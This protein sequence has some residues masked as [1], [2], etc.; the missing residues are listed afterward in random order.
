MIHQL[1]DLPF[2]SNHSFSKCEEQF[3]ADMKSSYGISV[4]Q[5]CLLKGASTQWHL[6][7]WADLRGAHEKTSEG[8]LHTSTHVLCTNETLGARYDQAFGIVRNREDEVFVS[9]CDFRDAVIS[10]AYGHAIVEIRKRLISQYPCIDVYLDYA[11]LSIVIKANSSKHTQLQ[12]SLQEIASVCL[13]C[14]KEFDGVG[15]IEKEDVRI[16]FID[17]STKNNQW[18]NSLYMT[19]RRL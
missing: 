11:T 1:S 16:L 17:E 2:P 10:Y 12:N 14:L 15:V 5:T 18:L 19:N 9:V 7:I 6:Y 4:L 8:I 13:L 3:K